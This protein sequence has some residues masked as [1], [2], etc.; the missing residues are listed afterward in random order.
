MSDILKLW[1]VPCTIDKIKN[2]EVWDFLPILSHS[3]AICY[4]IV[5]PNFENHDFN[6]T[7]HVQYIA[8]N[9]IS[10]HM[11]YTWHKGLSG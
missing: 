3:G 10:W 8:G 6:F 9:V 5:I 4:M 2:Y 1:M 7:K 11:A